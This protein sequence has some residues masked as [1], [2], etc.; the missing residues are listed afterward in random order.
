VGYPRTARQQRQIMGTSTTSALIAA[1][2]TASMRANSRALSAG[3]MVI[4]EL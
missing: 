3:G 4:R 2:V 1:S